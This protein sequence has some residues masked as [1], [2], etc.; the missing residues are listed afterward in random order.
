[1]LAAVWCLVLLLH[2]LLH[3]GVAG[4]A[5]DADCSL[6]AVLHGLALPLLAAVLAV[7]LGL[8]G[9]FSPPAARRAET[10]SLAVLS[11]RAPPVR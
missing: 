4:P 10:V 3:A 7:G 5:G 11:S 1:V 9:W 6:C 8:L 2:P